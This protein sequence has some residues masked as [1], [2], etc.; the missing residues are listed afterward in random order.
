M[1]KETRR[2]RKPPR[3]HTERAGE[4]V[5]GSGERVTLYRALRELPCSRCAGAIRAGELFTREVEAATGLP[6]VRRC[7]ACVP[8]KVGGG[9]LDAL[10]VSEGNDEAPPASAPAEVRAK[11][12]ARLGPALNARRKGGDPSSKK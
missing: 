9:L 5:L 4:A 11:V 10:F 12:L 1:K 8:F 6:L 3:P 7:R 2:D